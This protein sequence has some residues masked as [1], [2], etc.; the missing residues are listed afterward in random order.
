MPVWMEIVVNVIG[1]AGFIGIASYHKSSDLT[2]ERPP[3]ARWS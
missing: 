3:R 1:Y 2:D